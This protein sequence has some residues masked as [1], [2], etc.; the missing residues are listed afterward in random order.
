MLFSNRIILYIAEK[1]K[2]INFILLKSHIYFRGKS[3]YINTI[4]YIVEKLNFNKGPAAMLKMVKYGVASI[5]L[6]LT[7]ILGWR[8]YT[9]FF[10]NIPPMVMLSGIREEGVYAGDM[11]CTITGK[12]NYK[13]ADV[14]I[15]IDNKPV[16]SKFKIGKQ[17]FEYPLTIPTTTLPNGLHKL[18][19]E[20]TDSSYNCNKVIKEYGFFIDNQ[21]LQAALI[22]GEGD[23]KV[24][25]GR[26]LHLQ[27]QVNKDIT[28]TAYTLAGSYS[29]FAESPNS[30]IYECFIPVRTEEIPNEYLVTIEIVDKVGNKVTLENKFQVIAYPFKKQTVHIT[31]PKLQQEAELGKTRKEFE[32]NMQEATK[33][34]PAR[35]LWQ[36]AFYP[37]IEIK[38]ITTEFGTIR[39]TQEKGRYVHQG[40]DVT[41]APRSVIWAT[42][43]G[44]VVIKDRYQDSG[45]TVVI[46]HGYG[47]MSLFFHLDSFASIEVGDMIKKG[48]PIGKLG[49]TGYANGYHL[50]WEMRVNN[51]FVDPL[52]WTKN[53]F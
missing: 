24:F 43:D 6:M 26:T 8:L 13:V 14:S 27:F 31:P 28:A 20:L 39:T 22:S 3:S 50:H 47:V 48:S 49:M 38:N 2:F 23:Y 44:I 18:K 11:Q 53:N 25:Q 46:D 52:Q 51:I 32:Q 10:D 1:V 7:I 12:D 21:P 41:N 45:N 29:C 33:N 36:G 42:Q 35:K 37:P 19:I 5:F 4:K 9:Y 16:V 34:S 15:F 17:T 40:I 30:L